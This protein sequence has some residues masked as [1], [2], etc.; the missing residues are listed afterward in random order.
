MRHQ[1]LYL[2]FFTEWMNFHSYIVY[3][4]LAQ[5]KGE[6]QQL[7]NLSSHDF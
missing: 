5:Y 7:G 2:E 1:E 6:N 4:P 3:I